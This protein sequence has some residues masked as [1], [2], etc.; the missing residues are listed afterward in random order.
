MKDLKV[1][2]SIG[3][4]VYKICNDCK[5]G[6]TGECHYYNANHYNYCYSINNVKIF[7]DGGFDRSELQVVKVRV[8]KKMFF[9]ANEW[10][11]IE[12][13]SDKAEA[14]KA[15][16]EYDKIRKLESKEERFKQFMLWH[17]RRFTGVN[18]MDKPNKTFYCPV[19]GFETKEF[20]RSV[21]DEQGIPEYHIEYC[22]CCGT[23]R[24]SDEQR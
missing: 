2:C 18:F 22:P 12:F 9:N 23:R 4:E 3:E 15:M 13:F 16:D 21:A 7:P 20:E 14:Y 11:N 8:C 10:F 6:V 24:A 5:Y 19:C 1:N 17:S